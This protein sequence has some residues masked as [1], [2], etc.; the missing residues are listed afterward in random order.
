LFVSSAPD[1]LY[2]RGPVRLSLFRVRTSRTM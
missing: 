1:P 2:E